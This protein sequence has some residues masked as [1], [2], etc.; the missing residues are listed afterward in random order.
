MCRCAT[1]L[2]LFATGCKGWS[3]EADIFIKF[4]VRM[5]MAW[6]Q[7][8]HCNFKGMCW[9][10]NCRLIVPVASSKEFQDICNSREQAMARRF[11]EFS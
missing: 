4:V 5:R 2:P 10:K 6:R 11:F 1:Q 7:T 8:S 9:F 3:Q